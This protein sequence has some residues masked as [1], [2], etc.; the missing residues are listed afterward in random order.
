[1]LNVSS[2]DGASFAGIPVSITTVISS[3]IIGDGS[4]SGVHNVGWGVGK[5]ILSGRVLTI[6]IN[7]GNGFLI[8]RVISRIIYWGFK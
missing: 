4:T 5:R 2:H 7:A 3:A 6:P 1:M 8:F